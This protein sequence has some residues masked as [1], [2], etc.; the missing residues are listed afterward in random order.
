MRLVVALLGVSVLAIAVANTQDRPPGTT[1]TG[2]EKTIIAKERALY[3][4]V[5]K[6]DKASFQALV[7]PEGVWTTNTGF[8]PMR[9]LGDG[10]EVFH[11]TN[12]SIENPRV[13]LLSEASALVIYARTAAGRFGEE[14]IAPTALASTV[15][16]KRNGEWRVLHHQETDLRQ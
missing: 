12:L 6:N 1:S 15:W 4:A 5:A 8:V 10:L 3:D 16:V 7:L 13:T 11:L 9:L 14:A 2:V